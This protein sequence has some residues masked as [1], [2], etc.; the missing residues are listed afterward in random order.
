M[1]QDLSLNQIINFPTRGTSILDLLFTNRPDIFKSPKLLAGV[2]D[3]EIVS[4]KI[5][6]KPFFKK[7]AKRKILLWS[8]AD[9]SKLLAESK[10]LKENLF[11]LFDK[12][13]IF[14][15]SN[16][17]FMNSKY[18][19]MYFICISLNSAFNS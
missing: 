15:N 14:I 18:N 4:H 3:H 13:N 17:N 1:A 6:L 5:I 16:C 8:K 12:M 11:K 7:P 19:F 2:G 10:S 9:E